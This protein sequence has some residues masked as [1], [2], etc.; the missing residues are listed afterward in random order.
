MAERG[1]IIVLDFGSQYTQLIARRIRELGVFSEILPSET[2]SG[3][4]KAKGI[5][6]SGGPASVYEPDAPEYDPKIFTLGIPV[7][8][9]CYGMQLIAKELG[10][11]VTPGKIKEYGK[12]KIILKGKGSLFSGLNDTETVWMSHGDTVTR[13][14]E[15]FEVTGLTKDNLIAAMSNEAGKVYAVQFH[16]E[17]THTPNGMKLI[18][19]FVF[20]IC[21]CSP[22]WTMENFIKRKKDE[23][24]SEVRNKNVLVLVS[25]GVDSAVTAA[26]L[27]ESVN[28]DNLYAL[29]IDTGLMRKGETE[30]VSSLLKS[31]GLKNMIIADCSHD[32]LSALNNVSDPE[33][34]RRIIG[35]KFMEIQEREIKKLGLSDVLLAQGTLYTDM[36]ESG[37]GVGDK[38]DK[39][40]THHN[41]A[42]LMVEKLRGEGKLIEPINE[43]FKDE[44]RKVGELLHLPEEIIW[45]HPFPGPALAVRMICGR[46]DK[47]ETFDGAATQ[48]TKIAENHNLSGYLSPIKT[49]G[50]QGDQR[51]YRNLA[52][53]KGGMEWGSIKSAC[54]EIVRKLK[55]VNRVAYIVKSKLEPDQKRFE[56]PQ[57]LWIEKKNLDLLRDADHIV[58]RSIRKFALEKKISQMPV[59]LFPGPENPWIAIRPIK[60]ED[61]MTAKPL[62]I[63]EEFPVQC[64]KE[65][66]EQVMNLKRIDGIVYDVTDKPPATI[67]WE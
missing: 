47:D 29:Y 38:A 52:L 35:D 27:S 25:G 14:P 58:S 62:E 56:S 11:T 64:L 61:F 22:D 60:T 2:P 53:L 32:F 18:S 28:K 15:G 7:L 42:S 51:T 39:I 9:I 17:V 10:G 13:T 40:K 65:I 6:L 30:S 33:E 26:L 3:E 57:P 46:F 1:R 67:E 55:P 59:I 23:I 20:N 50:V 34:K 43:I 31:L 4:L 41:V 49:V 5:I 8:G 19:N 36:I 66:A 44:V 12:T 63:G 54:E 48:V 21:G 16:P 24:R 45:R 37:K